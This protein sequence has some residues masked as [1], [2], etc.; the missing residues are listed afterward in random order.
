MEMRGFVGF[1]LGVSV[2]LNIMQT[3]YILKRKKNK[4]LEA[5]KDE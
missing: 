3:C 5:M 4:V 2:T 1:L